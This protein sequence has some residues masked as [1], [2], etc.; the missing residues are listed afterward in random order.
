[1]VEDVT[2]RPWADG[3]LP[4]LRRTVGD[5]QQTHYLGGLEPS[6]KIQERHARY[7]S[8]GKPD[9]GRMVVI[10][11]GPDRIPAGYLLRCNDWVLDATAP[12]R[13]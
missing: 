10:V 7:L 6:E 5:A 9:A 13:A 11:A 4:L 1:M 2:L 3:D 12:A 8:L